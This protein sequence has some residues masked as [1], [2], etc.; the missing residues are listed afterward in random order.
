[1]PVAE[2]DTTEPERCDGC[3]YLHRMRR[4]FEANPNL[5]RVVYGPHLRLIRK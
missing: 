1:M 4:D 3:E 5:A 2:P